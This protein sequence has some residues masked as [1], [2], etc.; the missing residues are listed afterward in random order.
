MDQQAAK[1]YSFNQ[2]LGSGLRY[3]L[4]T[5]VSHVG[6]GGAEFS[7][8]AIVKLLER[9]AIR[10][11]YHATLGEAFSRLAEDEAK[12]QELLKLKAILAGISLND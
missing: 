11:N 3:Y 7:A 1:G 2:R 4:K 8:T 12:Q 5:D 9:G 6:S 10:I